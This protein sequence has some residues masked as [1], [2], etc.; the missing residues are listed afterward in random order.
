MYFFSLS[1]R[2]LS[3]RVLYLRTWLSYSRI[4][5][6]NVSSM[7]NSISLPS[8]PSFVVSA[9]LHPASGRSIAQLNSKYSKV[10]SLLSMALPSS[11]RSIQLVTS[12]LKYI[13]FLPSFVLCCDKGNVCE[14]ADIS[15]MFYR[16]LAVTMQ[17]CVLGFEGRNV[18]LLII[19]LQ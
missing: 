11:I 17:A 6:S 12:L 7:K 18:L 4:R 10:F 9:N 1:F 19:V 8:W 16:R 13:F 2:L 15:L 14:R 5:C 3:D